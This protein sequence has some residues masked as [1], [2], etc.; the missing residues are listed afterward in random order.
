MAVSVNCYCLGYPRCV[1]K[2]TK[3]QQL[4]ETIFLPLTTQSLHLKG[5]ATHSPAG[6]LQANGL[7]ESD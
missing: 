1:T 6:A 4:K 7:L 3:T 2:K 5:Q